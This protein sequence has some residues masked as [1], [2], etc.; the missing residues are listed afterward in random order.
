MS[1]PD[2][3]PLLRPASLDDAEAIAALSTQLGY[4]TTAVQAAA[5]L[6]QLVQE[7][8]HCVLVVELGGQVA[9]WAH[10][11]RRLIL[12]SGENAELMGLVVD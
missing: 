8:D 10:V 4:P 2:S 6:S 1:S 12:E 5:R 9:G 7:P 11:E 3:A